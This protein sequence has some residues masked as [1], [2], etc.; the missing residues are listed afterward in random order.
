MKERKTNKEK[1][2]EKDDNDGKNTQRYEEK[3]RR[4]WYNGYFHRK[5][6]FLSEFKF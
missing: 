3:R 6:I 1:S 5:W 4:T 2:K